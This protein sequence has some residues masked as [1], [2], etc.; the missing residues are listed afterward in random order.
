MRSSVKTQANV[1]VDNSGNVISLPV[2]VTKEGVLKSYLE[3]LVIYRFRSQSWIDRSVFSV[4]LLIDYFEENEIAFKNPKDLFREFVNCLFTGTISRDIVDPLGL[5]WVPRKVE[6]ANSIVGYL[7]HYADWL[8][9][10]NGDVE[11]IL[12]PYREASN[13]EQKLNWAAY[14]HRKNNQFL[15]HLCGRHN[16]ERDNSI[17]RAIQPHKKL[18]SSNVFCTVKAFPKNK[19]TNLLYDG[20]VLPGRENERDFHKRLNLRDVLITML[21]HFGGLRISEAIQLYSADIVRTEGDDSIEVVKVHH[22]VYGV[23]PEKENKIRKEFLWNKYGLKPRCE[24]STKS[25][26][27]TGWKSPLLTNS[28]FN[29]FTV[30]FF[31]SAAGLLFFELWKL[32]VI[33]QRVPLSGTDR[34]PYAFINKN[35]DPYSIKAYSANRKRAVKKIGLSYSK[36][37][38]TTPHA[39]RHS[40][41][42]ALAENGVPPLLIKTAMH[43]RS[44]ESQSTYTHPSSDVLR[45]RLKEAESRALNRSLFEKFNEAHK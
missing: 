35:G 45:E 19:I 6:D 13:Y 17:A 24:V 7:T 28:K 33:Y 9:L 27:F 21:M 16:Y 5:N 37:A 20:F 42:Q 3:Y 11:N 1:I 44:L 34:H 18:V 40:Y 2:V 23:S 10:A 8:A 43:H 38:C 39:D 14:H 26:Q 4:R 41:G 31:P 22:P 25:R 29:Y 30:E 15:S 36:E 12:N 32:Y